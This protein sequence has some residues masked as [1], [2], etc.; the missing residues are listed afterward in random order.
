MLIGCHMPKKC[1]RLFAAVPNPSKHERS[2]C[3]VASNHAGR[4]WAA[5]WMFVEFHAGGLDGS[6][7]KSCSCKC[8][9]MLLRFVKTGLL[10]KS[11]STVE[12]SNTVTTPRLSLAWVLDHS[13]PQHIFPQVFPASQKKDACKDKYF[14]E[15]P[16]FMCKD[17]FD[18]SICQ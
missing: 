2:E 7:V 5:L 9:L 3:T 1:T 10:R 14:T 6:A 18:V 4:C 15:R 11:N 8:L 13:V 17:H 12:N 16:V